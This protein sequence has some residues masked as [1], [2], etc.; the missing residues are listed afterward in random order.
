MS[1]PRSGNKRIFFFAGLLVVVIL[2]SFYNLFFL[3]P[4]FYNST[5]R[6]MR[7]VVKFGSILI[8]Y[9][10]GVFVFK[11]YT[12]SW[13]L[14][15]WHLLYAGC[16]IALVAI[17]LYDSWLGV[18]QGVRSFAVTLHEFLLSPVPYVVVGILNKGSGRQS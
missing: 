6:I 15:I 12:P 3:E 1:R 2:Y 18:G 11:R 8:V 17:G 7:H 14:S 5:S 16:T 9:G 4:W 13:P 10:T